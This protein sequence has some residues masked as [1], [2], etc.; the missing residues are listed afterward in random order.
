MVVL[1]ATPRRRVER[2][3]SE[4]F[5]FNAQARLFRLGVA[6][7]TTINRLRD[8]FQAT[9]REDWQTCIIESIFDDPL[10]QNLQNLALSLK[11]QKKNVASF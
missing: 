4:L 7:S 5:F 10:N 11:Q 8:M 9:A 2:I 6:A 3:A 1:A